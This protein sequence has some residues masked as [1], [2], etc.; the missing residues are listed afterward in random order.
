MPKLLMLPPAPAIPK[1]DNAVRLDIKFVEGMSYICRNWPGPVTCVL[2]QGAASIP[3]GKEFA[4]SQLPFS[5]TVLAAGDPVPT[6]MLADCDIVEASADMHLDLDLGAHGTGSRA[7]RAFVIEYTLGAR[8]KILQL[9]NGTP[10][11]KRAKSALWLLQQERRRRRA[12][13]QADAVQMNGFPAYESYRGLNS[14]S[15]I[16]MDNRM[17][18]EMM[19]NAD[20]IADRIQALRAGGPLRLINS[21]RLEPMK[22]AQDLL[23]VAKALKKLGVNFTL[24]IYGTGSLEDQISSGIVSS[25]L[26]DQVRVHSP[27]DFETELVPISRQKADLFLSCH[28][29][30]DPSCTYLEAMGCGL[31]IVGYKNAMLTPLVA[32]AQ[33]GWTV[34][35]GDSAALARKLAEIS[36]DADALE[37]ASVKAVEFAHKHDFE[38][39][40]ARRRNQLLQLMKAG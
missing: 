24:D 28:R 12:M 3:F 17:R 8:L 25:G 32:A 7:R 30:S 31:P 14:N 20:E 38:A 16:Y 6:E 27:I 2:R 37:I 13:R 34:S 23:P 35:Q 29:Q 1:G 10:L 5:L 15:L 22:G 4:P 19:S 33:T 36:L 39:E 9:D 26:Q 40:F 11:I 21:G 18:S